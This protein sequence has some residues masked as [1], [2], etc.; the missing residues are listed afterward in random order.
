MQTK[1][2]LHAQKRQQQR[3]VSNLGRN[4]L[5][6]FGEVHRQ[7]GNSQVCF[8]SKTILNQI[9]SYVRSKIRNIKGDKVSYNLNTKLIKLIDE[10]IS[11]ISGKDLNKKLRSF[12]DALEHLENVIA[13]LSLDGTVITILHAYKKIRVVH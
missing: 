3:G 9:T 1:L 4:V 11:T 13:V 10:F 2:S 7:K 5:L 12:L 8:I 6:T